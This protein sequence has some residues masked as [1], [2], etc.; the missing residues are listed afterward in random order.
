MIKYS[1]I[2]CMVFVLVSCSTNDLNDK[3]NS[4]DYFPLAVNNTWTYT[5]SFFENNLEG[6]SGK[7]TLTVSS[8]TEAEGLTYYEFTSQGGIAKGLVTGSLSTGTLTKTATQII[9]NGTYTLDLSYLLGESISI[10]VDNFIVYDKSMESGEVL[11]S[12]SNS[13]HRTFQLEDVPINVTLDYT[14]ESNQQGFLATFKTP[15]TS[16]EFED[17]LISRFV[18]NIQAEVNYNNTI[19]FKLLK[20]QQAVKSTNYYA[21]NVGLV[22][23]KNNINYEFEEIDF[24]TIPQIPNINYYSLQEIDSYSINE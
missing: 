13:L 7:E 21:K 12:L 22:Y 16:K 1:F 19:S 24:P 9:F 14:L 5:N 6:P 17:V 11:S 18:I 2:V 3:E 15:F 20:N 8:D 23:S 10:P 4:S